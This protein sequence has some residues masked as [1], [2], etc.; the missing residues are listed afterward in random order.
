MQKIGGKF[1]NF[2][3]SNTILETGVWPIEVLAMQR[4]YK[5]IK[6]VKNML[7][8]RLPKQAQT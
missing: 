6:K 2:L 8:H 5:Y 4:L 7:D 3:S 1:L